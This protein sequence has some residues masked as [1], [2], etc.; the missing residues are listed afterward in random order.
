MAVPAVPGVGIRNPGVSALT[1][2]TGP[3]APASAAP[4]PWSMQIAP[5]RRLSCPTSI[6]PLMAD[7]VNQPPGAR[8]RGE[9]AREPSL[10]RPAR[11]ITLPHLE[12][13]EAWL[14]AGMVGIGFLAFFVLVVMLGV[15]GS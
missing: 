11:P 2:L 13:G 6:L 5:E 8:D 1:S 9:P 7:L 14:I 15:A 3:S 12:R 10:L 4:L